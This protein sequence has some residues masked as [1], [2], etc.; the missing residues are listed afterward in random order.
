MEALERDK[1]LVGILR[2][3]AYTVVFDKVGCFA[4]GGYDLSQFDAG[5]FRLGG[6]F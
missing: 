4:P 5:A 3:E 1:K 2:R 6:E